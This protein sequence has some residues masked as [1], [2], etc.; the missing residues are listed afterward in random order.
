MSV[1]LAVSRDRLR[2]LLT[3]PKKKVVESVIDL[4]DHAEELISD[5]GDTETDGDDVDGR[6]DSESE[7]VELLSDAGCSPSDKEVATISGGHDAVEA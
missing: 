3:L 6:E 7:T 2:E 4:L 5:N 1:Y